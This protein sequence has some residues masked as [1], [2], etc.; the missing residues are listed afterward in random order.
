MIGHGFGGWQVKKLCTEV[1]NMEF[2]I[3]MWCIL[4]LY[5]FVSSVQIQCRPVYY[6]NLVFNFFSKY[7]YSSCAALEVKCAWRLAFL[8]HS[9]S[10]FSF[11]FLDL[12]ITRTILDFPWRFDVSGV[13]CGNQGTTLVQ[14]HGNTETDGIKEILHINVIQCGRHGISAL[15]N[16][17]RKTAHQVFASTLL[18]QSLQSPQFLTTVILLRK[19]MF[20]RVCDLIYSKTRVQGPIVFKSGKKGSCILGYSLAI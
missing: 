16:L 1:Q 2:N 20:G 3:N 8:L 11:F 4:C 10:L 9:I 13:D 6:S 12:P 15:I 17:Q 7:Q 19:K 5:F 14:R 18:D